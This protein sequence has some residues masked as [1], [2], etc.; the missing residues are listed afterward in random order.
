MLD[1]VSSI[2]DSLK[3]V[4]ILHVSHKLVWCYMCQIS[5]FDVGCGLKYIQ[6]SEVYIYVTRVFEGVCCR[7]PILFNTSKTKVFLM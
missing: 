3:Y 6:W 7:I 4:C 5:M 1:V 2:S